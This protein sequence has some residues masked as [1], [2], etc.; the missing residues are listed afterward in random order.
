MLGTNFSHLSNG[1]Q[2]PLEFQLAHALMH[3]LAIG[4]PLR[5]GPLAAAAANTDTVDHISLLCLVAKATGFVWT[6]GPSGPVDG[7]Q[8]TVLPASHTQQEA[9]QV[10][11][12]LLEQLLQVL[13]GSHGVSA[14]KTKHC[15]QMY[16]QQKSVRS[17][18]Y[19][20][21]HA[22]RI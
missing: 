19:Q 17:T 1:S 15:P 12:L 4:R 5:H 8:L 3:R 11:L 16:K 20:I 10:R 21:S 14:V 9:Q 2:T 18:F 6:G 13:V 7:I 22:D